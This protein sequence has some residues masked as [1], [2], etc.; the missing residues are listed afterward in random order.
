[1]PDVV[2]DD[3]CFDYGAFNR[4]IKLKNGTKLFPTKGKPDIIDVKQ[5]YTDLDCYFLAAIIAVLKHNPEKIIDC[6]PDYKGLSEEEVYAKFNSDKTIKIRFF[7]VK[8]IGDTYFPNGI[9]DIVVDK[10]ALRKKGVAWVRLLEKAYSIYK[11]KKCD[12]YGKEIP[13]KEFADKKIKSRIIDGIYGGDSG[14]VIVTLTG[15]KS[16]TEYLGTNRE[17]SKFKKFDKYSAEA[18]ALYN[19]IERYLNSGKAVTASANRG[20]TLYNKGLFF[21]HVY[22]VIGTEEKAGYKYFIL[23]NP[24][25]NR[26]RE[27]SVDS[28]GNYHSRTAIPK[29]EENKG[30]SLIE[31]NDFLRNFGDIEVEDD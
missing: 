14:S 23:K 16:H 25:A 19:R 2:V 30:I 8:I 11:T 9:I 6:F 12:G 24:Y 5:G 17:R 4:K 22:A 31:V 18:I 21:Q 26:S 10:T 29:E 7:K 3:R 15:K 20:R 28:K 1:M 13:D 27:Y